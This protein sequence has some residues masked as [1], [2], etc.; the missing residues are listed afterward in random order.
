M[1][2]IFLL[3]LLLFGPKKLPQIGRELGKALNEFRRASNEFK[4]QLETEIAQVEAAEQE[5]AVSAPAPAEFAAEPAQQPIAGSDSRADGFC[6]PP[7][8][9][10]PPQSGKLLKA[11][12]LNPCRQSRTGLMILIQ[13]L[14]YHRCNE[15]QQDPA[16]RVQ[17]LIWRLLLLLNAPARTNPCRRWVFSITSRSCGAASSGA[18]STSWADFLSA[19]GTT[20]RF[21]T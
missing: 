15:F 2:F 5:K 21:T 19:T 17:C 14:G 7:S 8:R 12:S 4:N 16:K 11:D 6:R 10:L 3:A 9:A 20:N 1:I 18:S 13:P